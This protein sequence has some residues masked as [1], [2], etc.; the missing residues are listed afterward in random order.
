[1]KKVN[2]LH[3]MAVRLAE[4]GIVEIGGQFV[5][6]KKV[7][8]VDNPCNLCNMDCVCGE[9]LSKLCS[10]VDKY[11]HSPNILEFLSTPMEPG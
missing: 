9:E 1:M 11:T 6:A 3:A 8:C 4:G 2:S 10:E 5:R 7:V